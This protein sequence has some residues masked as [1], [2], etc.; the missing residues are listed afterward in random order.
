MSL[1]SALP[2]KDVHVAEPRLEDV[3]LKLYRDD[4]GRQGEDA[5]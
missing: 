3:L 5:A 2:V 4:A 1:L